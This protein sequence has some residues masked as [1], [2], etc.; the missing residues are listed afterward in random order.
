MSKRGRN[1]AKLEDS[2]KH[3]ATRPE[4]AAIVEI[5][6][7]LA[8]EVDGMAAFDDKRVREYRLNLQVL[9]EATDGSGDEVDS[10]MDGLRASVGDSADA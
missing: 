6:R 1:R 5:C 8:D 4:H 10:F 7:T 9:M 3:L 2:L